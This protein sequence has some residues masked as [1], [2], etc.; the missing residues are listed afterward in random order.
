MWHDL[1]ELDD[2]AWCVSHLVYLCLF[3]GWYT[4]KCKEGKLKQLKFPGWS[5]DIPNKDEIWK[6]I[7]VILYHY[8]SILNNFLCFMTCCYY[9]NRLFSS[10]EWVAFQKPFVSKLSCILKDIFCTNS[11][12]KDPYVL[13]LINCAV[14]SVHQECKYTR[15]IS[16]YIYI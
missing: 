1:S 9:L 13:W 15:A 5:W 4:L 11:I 3:L 10:D 14:I 12:L 8:R 6:Y 7:N 16:E 2:T